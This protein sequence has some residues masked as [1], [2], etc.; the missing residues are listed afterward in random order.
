M[1]AAA[2]QI[3]PTCPVLE[4]L[5]QF[6]TSKVRRLEINYGDPPSS[7][8]P[9]RA[10]LPMKDLHALVFF[11]CV[12]PHTFIDALHPDLGLSEAVVCPK[13]KELGLVLYDDEEIIDIKC[14][15]RMAAARASM[16]AKLR[17]VAIVCQ[18]TFMPSDLLELEKHVLHVECGPDV[19]G[20]DD[21]SDGSDEEA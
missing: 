16:G 5:A 8:L 9:C 20:I 10:L 13:L 7:V 15:I 12:K 6:D 3:N 17:A 4:S 14:V 18:D 21:S 19:Y 11:Q 2:S 1:T